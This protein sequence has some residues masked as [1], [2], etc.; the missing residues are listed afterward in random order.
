MMQP[1]DITKRK[2][3]EVLSKKLSFA[4][5]LLKN[6]NDD[7]FDGVELLDIYRR[8]LIR[9][10]VA[11]GLTLFNSQDKV[12]ELKVEDPQIPPQY[13][14]TLQLIDEAFQDLHSFLDGGADQY[15]A[16]DVAR[17][18]RSIS[19]SGERSKKATDEEIANFLKRRNYSDSDNKKAL[20]LD[21]MEHFDISRSKVLDAA[22][23]NGLTKIN[24][25]K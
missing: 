12:D 6:I 16:R 22:K 14:W 8:N 2:F 21:A 19:H 3:P 20:I 11:R 17:T 25:S 23:N 4:L 1:D 7:G 9:N 13:L 15:V 24:K 10:T 5:A 18:A